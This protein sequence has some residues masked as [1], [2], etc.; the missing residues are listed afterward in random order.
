M[1]HFAQRFPG[2]RPVGHARIERGE[3]CFAERFFQIHLVGI[4]GS[5]R[6]LTPDPRTEKRFKARENRLH[7]GL[8]GGLRA[9]KEF[10]QSTEPFLNALD[11]SRIERRRKPGAPKASPA[12]SAT[13]AFSSSSFE[14]SVQFF[15]ATFLPSP[16]C[17]ET[18]GNA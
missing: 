18:F 13:C 2:E 6:T 7:H 9:G 8:G 1:P 3:P 14:S 12:T 10:F 11:R 17:A 16:R 15:A 4:P 5:E